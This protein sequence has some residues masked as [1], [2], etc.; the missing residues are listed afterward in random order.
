[1]IWKVDIQHVPWNLLKWTIIHIYNI[2]YGNIWIKQFSLKSG[3]PQDAWTP[4]LLKA[5]ITVVLYN[6][7]LQTWQ[8]GHSEMIS[9]FQYLEHIKLKN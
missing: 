8:G 5:G 6:L 1:M 9:I 4:I 7:D 3:H 2:N